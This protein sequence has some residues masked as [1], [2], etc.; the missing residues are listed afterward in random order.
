[1]LPER[2]RPG[3]IRGGAAGAARGCVWRAAPEGIRNGRRVARR[4]LHRAA[5]AAVAAVRI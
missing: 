5:A 3:A 4:S 1:M 2:Q